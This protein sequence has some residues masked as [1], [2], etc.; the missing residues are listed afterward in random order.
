MYSYPADLKV[1]VAHGPKH[2]SASILCIGLY[3]NS[4]MD[5]HACLDRHWL[6]LRLVL[7]VHSLHMPDGNQQL[8][9][10]EYAKIIDVWQDTRSAVK[11]LY[12][13]LF[14]T[15]TKDIVANFFVQ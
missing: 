7:K 13:I 5:A 12:S 8:R 15:A 10:F 1:Y 11:T 6:P 9:H 3:A 2:A 14:F 4:E